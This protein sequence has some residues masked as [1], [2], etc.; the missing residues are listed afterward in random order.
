VKE[1]IKFLRQTVDRRIDIRTHVE[2]DLW[3]CN[4]D[5]GQIQQVIMN[6]AVNARDAI[7][8][9]L[10][11]YLKTPSGRIDRD[12]AITVELKNMIVDK[13][14][15]SLHPESREGEFV[16]LSVSDSGSGMDRETIQHVFEPLFTA[17]DKDKGTGL[18]LATVHG[19]VQQHGGWID[20]YSKTGKGSTFYVYLPGA[21]EEGDKKKTRM[22]PHQADQT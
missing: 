13:E 10:G 19:I 3:M 21:S 2:P 18:G 20:I 22:H 17:K 5:M 12:P 15:V 4:A 1:T 9:G 11:G 8:E 14:Y 6:L 16:V 7:M